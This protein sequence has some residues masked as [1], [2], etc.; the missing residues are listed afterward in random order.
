MAL[1]HTMALISKCEE[2]V[3]SHVFRNS[4]AETMS[5]SDRLV[6]ITCHFFA[7]TDDQRNI[8]LQTETYAG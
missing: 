5:C 1:R 2:E 4:V 8:E 6:I 7:L 3:S